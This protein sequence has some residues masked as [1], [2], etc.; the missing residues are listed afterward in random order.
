MYLRYRFL[1][2]IYLIWIIAG[3]LLICAKI[4]LIPLYEIVE[5]TVIV[6]AIILMAI[7]T[8]QILVRGVTRLRTLIENH[9]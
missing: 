3:I 8:I 5:Q 1:V 2:G 7:G 4:G 6:G 9:Q